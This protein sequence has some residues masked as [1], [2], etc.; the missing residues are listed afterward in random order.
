MAWGE[1]RFS[2]RPIKADGQHWTFEWEMNLR[3][4][5][6][7]KKAI[8]INEIDEANQK[9]AKATKKAAGVLWDPSGGPG[10]ESIR[11]PTNGLMGEIVVRNM[12]EFLWPQLWK[13]CEGGTF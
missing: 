8:P 12:L 10:Q 9:L 6:K 11:A 5:N 2:H 7:G 13:L 3:G 1:C 4:G